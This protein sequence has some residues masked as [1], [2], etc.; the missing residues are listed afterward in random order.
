MKLM[1]AN[2]RVKC[3][4]AEPLST[5]KLE[6]VDLKGV[7]VCH[8]DLRKANFQGAILVGA[9][10][11]GSDLRGAS[12]SG[13]N[14]E[15][16]HFDDA[17]LE[18]ATLQN[19]DLYWTTFYR[20]D[21]TH[22]NLEDTRLRGADLKEAQLTGA[23]LRNADLGPDNLG[24]A[25]QLQGADLTDADV[26]GARLAGAE[27]DV[28][29]LLPARIDPVRVGMV[30]VEGKL[31]GRPPKWTP[32]C[33]VTAGGMLADDWTDEDDRLLEEIYQDRKK[34]RRSTNL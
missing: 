13:A 33:T 25:T 1:T 4:I 19:A 7:S 10:F 2:G 32:G 3:E 29:T 23:S 21:L 27:Y 9:D 30:K 18:D 31:P 26:R 22:A 28:R 15:G 20:A 14:L 34:D 5:A 24:G 6:G 17:N 8:Q 16:A 12:F 11:S